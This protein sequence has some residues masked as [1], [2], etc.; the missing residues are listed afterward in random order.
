MASHAGSI[1][2]SNFILQAREL[3]VGVA[4]VPVVFAVLEAVDFAVVVEVA[5][6]TDAGAV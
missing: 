3:A 6:D 1:Q 2:P 4:E 5:V